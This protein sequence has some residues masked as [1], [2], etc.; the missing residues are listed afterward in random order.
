ME[1]LLQVF[2]MTFVQSV[3]SLYNVAWG[4]SLV[5]LLT[6]FHGAGRRLT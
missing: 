3:E 6:K 2:G 5:L 4:V 1:E